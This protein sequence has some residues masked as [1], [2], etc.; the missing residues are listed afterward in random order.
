MSG[1]SKS[2]VSTAV[3]RSANAILI[4]DIAVGKTLDEGLEKMMQS[5]EQNWA[6]FG[7]RKTFKTS[8]KAS[9]LLQ[10]DMLN[11]A[12]GVPQSIT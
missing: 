2:S 4:D 6:Q 9:E 5:T 10:G 1:H 8:E 11:Q 12:E 7:R 3:S